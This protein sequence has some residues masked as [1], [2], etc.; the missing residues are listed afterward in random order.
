[1]ETTARKADGHDI[2]R[3]RRYLVD[4]VALAER[5]FAGPV[6]FDGSNHLAFMALAF[7]GK[8]VVHAR[9]ILT[10]QSSMDTT[11]VAR[12]MFE[13]RAN[14]YGQHSCLGNARSADEHLRLCAT[15]DKCASSV[16][17]ESKSQKTADS[18]SKRASI[19]SATSS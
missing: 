14:W 8:Q 7:A 13:G 19:V 16:S 9:S 1:M 10:L 18:T 15:G 5:S 4:L 17:R 11:L 12:S 2:E 6:T 3:L